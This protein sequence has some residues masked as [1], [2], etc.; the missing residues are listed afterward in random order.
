MGVLLGIDIGTTATK[1]VALD[2]AR[3]VVGSW[4]RPAVIDNPVPGYAQADPE[5]WWA[6]VC[7]LTKEAGALPVDA[8][9]VT[10]MVPTVILLDGDGVPLTASIQQND[11]RAEHEMAELTARL[12]GT[13]VLS[14]T[15]SAISAQS[16]GPKLMW[17]ARHAAGALDAARSVVGSYDFVAARLTGRVT[18]EANWAL[19]SGL[20]DLAAAKWSEP[21]LRGSGV[22]R[23]LLPPVLES[24]DPIGV[25]TR[26]AA[27]AT[28]LRAGTPVYTGGADHVLSA[29]ASGITESGQVLVKIGG[30]GDILAVSREPVVDE[31]L[32]LDIHAVP[33]R[34]LPNGCMAASGSAIRWFA[35]RLAAGAPLPVLDAEAA[36]VPAGANGVVFLPYL[37]GE[38]TPV[39][40]PLAR[41]AFA[42][43][44]LGAG[45]EVLYRAVLE[46]I[47]YGFRQHLDVL[48]DLGLPVRSVRISDGGAR[49]RLFAGII[50]DVLGRPLERLGPHQSSALGAAYVAGMG[51]GAFTDWSAVEWLV[52]V[53]D[54]IDP[55]P[56]HAAAHLA[57]YGVYSALYPALRGIRPPGGRL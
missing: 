54:S 27:A 39:N 46:G 50:S 18:V 9:A 20:W 22:P 41:G 26:G 8:V 4:S 7:A 17:L 31:R 49:S 36:T 53:V 30:A 25:V 32:Y 43:L 55:A 47:A 12:A 15:A 35:E 5:Q 10:G 2:P 13:D 14:T 51:A 40:D 38:K 23:D 56:E 42:G 3:G 57:G 37:L 11:V 44:Y 48:A 1:A 45:R 21:M 29:L 19:E 52:D 28:G 33:G 6:N 16:V 34:F 24:G